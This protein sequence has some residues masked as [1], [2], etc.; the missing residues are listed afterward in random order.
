VAWANWL[1]GI[2]DNAVM[3]S[4]GPLLDIIDL[5]LLLAERLAAG[6]SGKAEDSEL[7]REEA[8][9]V[10]SSTMHEL[11]REAGYGGRFHVVEYARLVSSVLSSGTVRRNESAHPLIAIWGTL[12]ARVMGAELVI[13]AGLNEGTWPKNPAPDPWLSRQMRLQVG[14]LSPERQIGL[15]AH[16]F[17][18]A[19][20][21]PR[22]VLSRSIRDAEAETVPSR[23]LARLTN[24][25]RGLPEQG[26]VAAIENMQSRG[27]E[28]LRMAAA[29]ETPT[30]EQ[31]KNLPPATRPAPRP[32]ID[33]RPNELPVT[34][35]RTLIRDPYALYARRVLR[36]RALDPLR[37]VPDARLRGQVLHKIVEDFIR[38][39]PAGE[40][41]NAA[42]DRLIRLAGSVL[43][44][45]IPWPS[46]QRIWLAKLARVADKFI[47]SET[48]RD[49]RGVPV[50]LE[51]SGSVVLESNNFTLTARPDR[52]DLLADGRVHI[53]DYKTGALPS[54]KQQEVFDKQLLLEAAMTERGGFAELGRR[55]VEAVTY[56]QMGGDGNEQE[57]PIDG[58]ILAR[59]WDQ[60]HLLVSAYQRREI[61]YASRRAVFESRQDG[62]Y[63][64][65]ARFGEWE[66]SDTPKPEDVG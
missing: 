10:A 40:T 43:A 35:I 23:W 28:W 66:M 41:E 13:L 25:L 48:S 33:A 58:D 38:Q 14:L 45:E 44:T 64:H 60:L 18:Q 65:L 21:A 6:P 62:D 46:A 34:G 4:G 3:A 32:P 7:W 20:N 19:A 50:I 61:G 31:K 1:A 37:A 36:L 57:V 5:H 49:A 15:S 27:A 12:E 9:R 39:R 51:K 42:R 24:L 11:Q 26:G 63:D 55:D 17:Q 54:K 56:I 2:L 16:D 47:A 53:Y 59:T 29:L 8:G 52:I 22:V 30:S